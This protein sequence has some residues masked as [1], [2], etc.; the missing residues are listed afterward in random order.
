MQSVP[1]R[2]LQGC[3]RTAAQ[4]LITRCQVRYPSCVLRAPFGAAF[5]AHCSAPSAIPLVQLQGRVALPLQRV[6]QRQRLRD[7]WA[8]EGVPTGQIDME[9][10]WLRPA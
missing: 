4:L 6:I 1:R 10:E 8:L 9:L 5:G 2:R 3:V 7:V